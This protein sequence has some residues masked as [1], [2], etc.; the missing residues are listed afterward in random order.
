MR[1]CEA[2]PYVAMVDNGTSKSAERQIEWMAECPLL[3]QC[4]YRPISPRAV[5]QTC[6]LQ[7]V[8]NY[9]HLSAFRGKRKWLF[10]ARM[11]A[12]DP[13][14]TS[15]RSSADSPASTS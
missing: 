9:G 14:R 8:P 5:P 1:N 13:K 11:S 7:M 3:A 15:A 12:N 2:S 4:G 10:A 6:S